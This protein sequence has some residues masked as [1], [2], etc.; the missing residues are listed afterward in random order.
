MAKAKAKKKFVES[1]KDSVFVPLHEMT[2]L[3]IRVRGQ[4]VYKDEKKKFKSRQIEYT[5]GRGAETWFYDLGVI[6]DPFL[7]EKICKQTY[8]NVITSSKINYD[9]TPTSKRNKTNK[10]DD[11]EY[12]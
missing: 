2:D 11:L 3:Q 4:Y 5:T 12:N 6:Y 1:S 9:G 10:I 8:S 7:P